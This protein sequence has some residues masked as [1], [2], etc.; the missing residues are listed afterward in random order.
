MEKSIITRIRNS[1]FTKG[2]A[3]TLALNMLFEMVW[4]TAAMALTG[5]PSQPEV[6]SFEP[7]ET[8]DMVDLF[9]GD[10]TYNIPLINLPGPNGGY[11]INLSYHGGPTMDEEASWV[12]LGWNINAGAL[13]RNV[14]G[15]ADDAD[16]DTLI[17]KIDMKPNLTVGVSNGVN[18]EIVGADGGVGFDIGADLGIRYNNYKGF[19]VSL[20]GTVAPPSPSNHVDYSFGLSLDSETGFGVNADVSYKNTINRASFG[21]KLGLSYTNEGLGIYEQ[22]SFGLKSKKNKGTIPHG[23]IANNANPQKKNFVLGGGASFSF[24]SNSHAPLISRPYATAHSNFSIKLGTATCATYLTYPWSGYF[25]I[26]KIKGS[27]KGQNYN[28][29]IYGYENL[30][31]SNQDDLQDFAREKDGTVSP[32]LPNLAAPMLTYDTYNV[33]GQGVGGSFRPYRTDVGKIHNQKMRN[34]TNGG[35]LAF[36]VSWSGHVGFGGTYTYGQEQQRAWESDNEWS[37][38]NFEERVEK[39]SNGYTYSDEER[40]YY[41]MHGDKASMPLN[42]M[43]YIGGEQ[44]VRPE[45]YVAGLTD[46]KRLKT[47]A[48]PAGINNERQDTSRVARNILVHKYSNQEL[49]D[50]F[51]S[52]YKDLVERSSLSDHNDISEMSIY[53]YDWNTGGN[54]NVWDPN[55]VPHGY[56]KAEPEK[57]LNREERGPKSNSIRHHNA[58]YKV[59]NEQGQYYVYGLP[60]YNNVETSSMFSVDGNGSNDAKIDLDISTLGSTGELNYE[61]SGTDK[62]I[63]KTTKAPYAHSYMLTSVLG[64]DYVDVTGDGATD[65]DLG[66]WV[67]FDYTKYSDDYKWRAPYCGA[68]YDRGTL[69]HTDDDKGYYSYGEKEL[70]YLAKMETKTHVLVYTLSEREDNLD[71]AG[72]YVNSGKGDQSGLKIDKISLYL[73]EDYATTSNPVALQEVHFEYDY[74]LCPDVLNN[75]GNVVS[76][77]TDKGKLT[78]KKVWFTF[79][80]SSKGS[81]SPYEFDYGTSNNFGYEEFS[82]DRW[83]AYKSDGISASDNNFKNRNLPYVEQSNGISADSTQSEKDK[84]AGAWSLETI[85][86]PSGGQIDI[87]YEADDYAYVQNEIATQMF[88]ITGFNDN[89][90]SGDKLYNMPTAGGVNDFTQEAQRRIYFKLETPIDA[91]LDSSVV[92]DKIY[93]EY[94]Y[95]L[96]QDENGDRNL[97]FK[98]Y[99]DLRDGIWQYV[100]GY[101]PIEENTSHLKDGRILYGGSAPA[102]GYFQEGFITI[103]QQKKKIKSKKNSTDSTVITYHEKYHPMAIAAWQYMRLS[104]PLLLSAPA[105]IDLEAA[106]NGSKQ[107]KADAAANLLGFVPQTIQMFTG[108]YAYCRNNHF[109][110]TVDLN[111]SVIRLCT[112]DK[113]KF[114]GG[115][116]VKQ[117]S[118]NDNWAEISG[119]SN[120]SYGVEYDYTK[121]ENG[122]VISS[123]VAQ[124]EPKLGGDEIALRYPKAYVNNVPFKSDV[125]TYFEHPLNE[126]Y[127]PAASVGYSQV[128]M[129]TINTGNQ[130]KQAEQSSN[131]SGIGTT[132]LTTY[133][134]YTAKDFPVIVEE[135]EIDVYKLNLNIPLPFIGK[136]VTKK[137]VAIQGYSIELNDMHGKLKSVKSYGLRSD[138]SINQEPTSSVHYF[139]KSKSAF[140]KN[141]GNVART[142]S[143]LNNEVKTIGPSNAFSETEERLVGIEYEFLTDQRHNSSN[144]VI[145]GANSNIDICPSLIVLPSF[146]PSF[147]SINTT[148]KTLVTNK[149]V[150]KSGILEKVVTTDGRSTVTTLNEVYDE[151]TG[152]PIIV[153]TNNEFNDRIYNYS[154]PAH[155]EYDR[156]GAAYKNIDML[157]KGEIQSAGNFTNQFIFETSPE[158]I[159]QLVSGDVLKVNYESS[160]ST[161]GY[162]A[163]YLGKVSSTTGVFHVDDVGK[164]KAN[165]N[166]SNIDLLDI[167]V[168]KSGRKNHLY[169]DAGS[170]VT[171]QLPVINGTYSPESSYTDQNISETIGT[172]SFTFNNYRIY[173][174]NKVINS[175]A[176]VFKDEWCRSE[177]VDN[178]YAVGEAGIWR[179]YRSYVYVGDRKSGTDHDNPGLKTAGRMDS[180]DLFDWQV[181]NFENYSPN[182]HWTSEITRY[183][184]EAYEI[185]NVNRLGI[186]SAALYSN[187]GSLVQAVGANSSHHEIGVEDFEDFELN[188]EYKNVEMSRETNLNFFNNTTILDSTKVIRSHQIERGISLAN[189]QFILEYANLPAPPPIPSG[190]VELDIQTSAFSLN[191]DLT[192]VRNQTYRIPCTVISS[193]VVGSKVQ[194]TVQ[195]DIVFSGTHHTFISENKLISGRL[196]DID[197]YQR[198]GLSSSNIDSTNVHFTNEKAHTGEYSMKIDMNEEPYYFSQGGLDLK[199]GKT[200]VL[201]AW[202][203]QNNEKK[204]NFSDVDIE[205]AQFVN[206]SYWS[207]CSLSNTKVRS[208]VVEGWQ[209]IEM[210]FEIAYGTVDYNIFG[211]KITVSGVSATSAFI[212]DIRVSPKT[213]GIVTYVYDKHNF[214]LR[215][216]LDQNNFSTLYYY[217]E[218]G[219]LSLTKRE[220]ERGIQTISENR[221]N[222][223][224]VIN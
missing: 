113:K 193:A 78:L 166:L 208:R 49:I 203:S 6:Q 163:T 48:V 4:P 190:K 162:L 121:I 138:Y 80:G 120:A 219:N 13:V 87:S 10:F 5:G 135:T 52:D 189:G 17:T 116:R 26:Q 129:R 60:A 44:A 107:N 217:D 24:S 95:G 92:A 147:S 215:A 28:E 119:E 168:V 172:E 82:H 9:S 214:R 127:Y 142:F 72:E 8:T 137:I 144:T 207:D 174:I 30:S 16:G 79:Q 196:V 12:G 50:L 23:E 160:G 14:R 11:P 216:Q 199:E 122:K 184:A 220:T 21:G 42:E 161:Y 148:M 157:F 81:L 37:T 76:N 35:S 206:N 178:P 209:K 131:S 83:G 177:G 136:L 143:R 99:T 156:M 68:N 114:G 91:S 195:S 67:R 65:D 58:G 94:I 89:T 173:A 61:I 102:G 55:A 202:V 155:W 108:I 15:F 124:Y 185:E 165:S 59:L 224:V 139:Y 101:I 57:V 176:T 159:T 34:H 47:I 115:Q 151:Q 118:M 56:F 43:D 103:E 222:N 38:F 221:G 181:Q 128:T 40:M 32:N 86:L 1:Y 75:T 123:G 182:W 183:N 45:D 200:Y 140:A 186:Y 201:S 62:F 7:I 164:T 180:V 112:P 22:M 167:K 3:F 117:I 20:G 31:N 27:R 169:A 126:N 69:A 170:L 100:S 213:G 90:S 46:R 109:G 93:K 85:H 130:I 204:L 158:V 54:T 77:N 194:I 104:D 110:R 53:Y 212:D 223:R 205:A 106:A 51:D 29:K 70:W 25:N 179:P 96:I 192:D 133:E 33:L 19:G 154:H 132:G 66:Y 150:F 187:K 188:T 64:A 71:A 88:Q 146:W 36:D 153:S 73:K 105:G 171:E 74:S 198:D 149:V 210:E 191:S 134:F 98:N 211:I 152:R 125:S 41:R 197:D 145:G 111:N 84:I 63:D 175:T 218:E 141:N 97:Y 39:T 18:K 2:L